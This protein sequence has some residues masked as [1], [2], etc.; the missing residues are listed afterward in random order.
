[1]PIYEYACDECEEIVEQL[2]HTH[3]DK[4]SVCQCGGNLRQLFGS[5]ILRWSTGKHTITFENKRKFTRPHDSHDARKRD[6]FF[7]NGG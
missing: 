1:M 3:S 2:S 5:P 7:Q 6:Y 4:L